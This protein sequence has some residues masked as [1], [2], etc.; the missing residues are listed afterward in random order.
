MYVCVFTLLNFKKYMTVTH[1]H[2]KHEVC[3]YGM[4][5]HW[6]KLSAVSSYTFGVFGMSFFNSLASAVFNGFRYFTGL[7]LHLCVCSTSL[8]GGGGGGRGAVRENF[9]ST[10][11]RGVMREY[12]C[13]TPLQGEGVMREYICS[14]PLQ[15]EVFW[16]SIFVVLHWG[17]YEGVYL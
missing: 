3:I 7:D 10:P 11:L 9:C 6:M 13:S 2:Q 12:I 8:L 17:G 15:G 5:N 1:N 14:T 4:S 16:G